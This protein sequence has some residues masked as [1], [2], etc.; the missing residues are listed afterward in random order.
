LNASATSMV[1]SRE[2]GEAWESVKFGDVV[3]DVKE[4]ERDPSGVGLERYV[5]LEH[6]EPFNFELSEWGLLAEGDVS[7]TKCFRSG[8]VLFGK[9][10]AYQR[11]VAVA[12]FDGICSSDILTFEAIEERLLPELLPFVVQSDPFFEHALDTSSGSLSPRIRWSQLREFEFPLPDSTTQLRV[13]ELLVAASEAE[14]RQRLL[15]QS[16]SE[17]KFSLA[18]HLWKHGARGERRVPSTIGEV[19]ESWSVVRLEEHTSDSAYGPGFP[20]SQYAESG[21][22]QTIRTT[23]F[24][25]RGGLILDD[26]PYTTLRAE[27]IE[28]HQL[29]V[30]D[31]LLSRSGEYAGLTATFTEASGCFIAAAF[32][33]RFQLKPSLLSEYLVHLCY[34]D[35]GERYVLPLATGSAQPNIS[36][37]KLLNVL[38]PVPPIDGQ[39]NINAVLDECEKSISVAEAHLETLRNLT[40]GLTNSFMRGELRFEVSK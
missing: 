31:F 25:R 33:I 4:S 30:G 19:P 9:R 10:R 18:S 14:A 29:K 2:C 7:F 40:M 21:N 23:D 3:R 12:D 15:L 27:V 11:K 37:T 39:R 1:E 13:A 35:F 26:V 16:L 32:C 5:G 22:V 36:G 28:K 24:D 20:A 17:Y 34:S 38:V 8:Q 6:L